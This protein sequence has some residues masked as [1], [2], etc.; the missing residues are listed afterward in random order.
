M[1]DDASQ[2]LACSES[3]ENQFRRTSYIFEKLIGRVFLF[4][5]IREL[6]GFLPSF[7]HFL[8]CQFLSTPRPRTM[9]LALLALL[10]L[11]IGAEAQQKLCTSPNGIFHVRV[12]IFSSV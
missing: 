12:D 1:T 4:S 10:Y 11:A 8:G 9:K 3:F 2:K 6:A 5:C 7:A